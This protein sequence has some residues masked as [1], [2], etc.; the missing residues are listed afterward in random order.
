M[1]KK[2]KNIGSK[3]QRIYY[4]QRQENELKILLL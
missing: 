4:T 2:K 3:T 1:G